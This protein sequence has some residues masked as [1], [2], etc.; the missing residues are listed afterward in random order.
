M[1]PPQ[2]AKTL[3][4]VLGA[5]LIVLAL[6]GF[7]PNPL[8]GSEGYFRTDLILNAVL[9]AIGV[10]LLTFTTKGEGTAA[11]G[12]FFGA[13]VAL[14]LAAVGYVQI[15][16]YPAGM[17]VKLFDLVACNMQSIYLFGGMAVVMGV[18]GMMNT[19][20]RQVIRD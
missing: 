7:L 8:I 13:M 11:T 1:T 9:A 5:F 17:V 2:V 10:L 20:S 18:A 12:L 6:V 14:G 15:S 16:E 4:R 19:S 3:A